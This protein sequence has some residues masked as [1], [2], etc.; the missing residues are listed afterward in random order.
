MGLARSGRAR[1]RAGK[2]VFAESGVGARQGNLEAHGDGVGRVGGFQDH[3]LAGEEHLAREAV[4]GVLVRLGEARLAPDPR[5]GFP[6]VALLA[7]L[8]QRLAAAHAVCAR[9]DVCRLVLQRLERIAPVRRLACGE[10]SQKR[11]FLSAFRHVVGESDRLF[12]CALG[13]LDGRREALHA[14]PL[15]ARARF[16][17]VERDGDGELLPFGKRHGEKLGGKHGQTR[18]DDDVAGRVEAAGKNMRAGED[19]GLPGKRDRAH[20]RTHALGAH[21]GKRERVAFPHADPA[22]GAGLRVDRGLGVRE[23]DGAFRAGVDA[24]CARRAERARAEIAQEDH[25]ARFARRRTQL[26]ATPAAR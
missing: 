18:Q 21:V 23:G 8:L 24:A 11:A 19:D 13:R 9:G 2:V 6:A 1:L 14:A 5:L 12:G 25:L 15:R 22:R 17:R 3:P 20:M 10:R 16:A 26:A 7:R 4:F